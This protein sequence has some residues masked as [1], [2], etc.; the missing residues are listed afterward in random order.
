LVELE[1]GGGAMEKGADRKMN[2]RDFTK[3]V[4]LGLG[5]TTLPISY[6]SAAQPP[7]RLVV[8]H[9]GI[10]WGFSNDNAVT[11]IQDCG[12]LGY[13]GFESFGN[14]IEAWEER[15]GIGQLLEAANIPLQGAYCPVNLRN[16]DTRA[17]EVAKIVRWGTL[18]RK[19]G[20][21]IAVVGPGGVGGRGGGNFNFA[22][23]RDNIVATLN[24][25]CMALMDVGIVG[26]LH[27]HTGT[28]VETGEHARGVFDNADT[29]YVKFC[30]DVGQLMKAGTDPVPLVR[31]YVSIVHHVHMKDY[32]GGPNFL[33]YAPLGRGNLPVEELVNILEG[34][35]STAMIMVELDPSGGGQGAPPMPMTPKETAEVAKAT[36]QGLRYTFRV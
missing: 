29:R 14:V 7:R 12:S 4:A 25:M 8:G 21:T 18:I 33:G 5:A 31:D 3:M 10:T 27:P 19:Y 22:D 36:M 13:R 28:E 23:H 30:P 6:L 2:R 1:S 26:A 35:Q 34:S 11:A 24:D 32:D 20:G 9:T 16:P 17:A 15:G